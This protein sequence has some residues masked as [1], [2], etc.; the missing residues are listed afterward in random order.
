GGHRGP[1]LQPGNAYPPGSARSSARSPGAF[2][3]SCDRPIMEVCHKIHQE[4]GLLDVSR[5]VSR[6]LT[7]G[8]NAGMSAVSIIRFTGP[9]FR[10]RVEGPNHRGKASERIEPG[11]PQHQKSSDM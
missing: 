5:E 8:G 10:I 4:I 7:A 11:E 1:P 6:F 9:I 3:V 2:M